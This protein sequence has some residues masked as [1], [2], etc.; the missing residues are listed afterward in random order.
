MPRKNMFGV[1]HCIRRKE[2]RCQAHH[3]V[4]FSQFVSYQPLCSLRRKPTIAGPT[5]GRAVS[6]PLSCNIMLSFQTPWV[7]LSVT[8]HLVAARNVPFNRVNVCRHTHVAPMDG[9]IMQQNIEQARRNFMVERYAA[10]KSH[11]R[12]IESNR[13]HHIMQR[14]KPARP[15]RSRSCQ[16]TASG[17]GRRAGSRRQHQLEYCFDAAASLRCWPRLSARQS[18]FSKIFAAVLG[19]DGSV[20]AFPAQSRKMRTQT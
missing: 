14:I 2:Q 17:R 4:G 11:P 13:H 3:N 6:R 1:S 8:C 7:N 16:S 12:H 20:E 10:R 15:I 5:S 18:I 9:Q 19:R